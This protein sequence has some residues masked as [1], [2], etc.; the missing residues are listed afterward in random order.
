MQ[1][2]KNLGCLQQIIVRNTLELLM[3]KAQKEMSMLL[4]TGG[5]APWLKA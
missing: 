5:R 2:R 1:N 3:E 4:D